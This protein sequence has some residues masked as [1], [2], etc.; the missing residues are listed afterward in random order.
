MRRALRN[1]PQQVELP[2]RPPLIVE[3]DGQAIVT[4]PP[5]KADEL[6]GALTDLLRAAASDEA[7]VAPGE[8][9]SDDRRQAHR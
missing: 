7:R 6:R 4:L 1:R 8:G 9:G 3:V 5:H 2:L